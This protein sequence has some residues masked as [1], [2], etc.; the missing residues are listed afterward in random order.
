MQNVLTKNTLGD[1]KNGTQN[2]MLFDNSV[3]QLTRAGITHDGKPNPIN[4]D[5]RL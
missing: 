1:I 4:R 3:A 2:N 5:I